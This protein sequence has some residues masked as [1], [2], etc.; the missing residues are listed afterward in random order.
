MMGYCIH[1]QLVEPWW[2]LQVLT[3]ISPF[4]MSAMGRVVEYTL[5]ENWSL[6]MA[7]FV[8]THGFAMSTSH[9]PTDYPRHESVA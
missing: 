2:I 8:N 7:I 1:E 9:L 6:P 3:E 4:Q 5:Q